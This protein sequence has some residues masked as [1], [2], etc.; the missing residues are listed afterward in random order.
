MYIKVTS[1]RKYLKILSMLTLGDLYLRVN[2]HN[3]SIPG[4]LRAKTVLQPY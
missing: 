3:L 2:T 1:M 4:V